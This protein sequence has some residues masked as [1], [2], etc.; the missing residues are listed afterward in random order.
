MQ[1]DHKLGIGDWSEGLVVA[2]PPKSTQ[3][4]SVELHQSLL[5]ALTH[6][7]SSE[8]LCHACV[9]LYETLLHN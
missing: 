7:T 1:V 5:S 6:S 9:L 2:L 3:R 8:M 4:P